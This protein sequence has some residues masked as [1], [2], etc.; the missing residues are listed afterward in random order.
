MRLRIALSTLLLASLLMVGCSSVAKVMFGIDEI[1]EYNAERVASFYKESSSLIPCHQIVATAAQQDSA[2]RIDLDTAMMQHRGQMVQV[3]Y[4]DGDSLVFYH[5]SCYTQ[6]GLFRTDW[7]TYGS[8]NTFPPNP[9]V[10]DDPHGGMTFEAYRRIIPG[11]ASDKR[12]KV[13]IVWS[14]VL[15][16]LSQ[17]AMRTVA[18]NV[19]GRDDV[20]VF[21]VNIDQWFVWYRNKH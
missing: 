14:N 13:I 17:K 2:I 3:L 8:F 4:F 18:D 12:Y 20:D 16:P 7:N 5:I 21:L 15:R 9:T 19:A 1:D 6:K 11:L 10:V